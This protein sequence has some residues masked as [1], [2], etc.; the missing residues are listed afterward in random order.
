[1]DVSGPQSGGLEYDRILYNYEASECCVGGTTSPG[2]LKAVPNPCS[3]QQRRHGHSDEELN[4][5]APGGFTGFEDNP[6]L[7]GQS[8]TATAVDP[9]GTVSFSFTGDDADGSGNEIGAVC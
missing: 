6:Y 7:W 2:R 4:V 9:G 3:L 5:T 1:M 8:Q